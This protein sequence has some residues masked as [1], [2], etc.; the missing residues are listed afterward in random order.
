A[1]RYSAARR[2]G[3]SPPSPIRDGSSALDSLAETEPRLAATSLPCF[4][5]QFPFDWTSSTFYGRTT[6]STESGPTLVRTSVTPEP[7]E[8]RR[9][10]ER[11][12]YA[13]GEPSAGDDNHHFERGCH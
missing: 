10:R 12:S 4:N 2:R 8:S 7:R 9:Q 5:H 6:S 11:H 3:R 1:V 13:P